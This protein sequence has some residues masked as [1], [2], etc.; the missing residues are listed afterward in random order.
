MHANLPKKDARGNNA[1]INILQGMSQRIVRQFRKFKKNCTF[2][3]A[4]KIERIFL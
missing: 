3:L 4:Q 2:T 1:S